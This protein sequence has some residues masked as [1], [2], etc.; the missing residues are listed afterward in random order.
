MRMP[1]PPPFRNALISCLQR[2][3]GFQ[4][5]ASTSPDCISNLREA[6][7]PSRIERSSPFEVCLGGPLA[8]M[9]RARLA[10]VRTRAIRSSDPSAFANSGPKVWRRG[11]PLRAALR[12][13]Q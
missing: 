9:E 13:T 6:A 2:R 10:R 1:E 12:P 8:L 5:P 11:A 4:Q 7:D 3:A